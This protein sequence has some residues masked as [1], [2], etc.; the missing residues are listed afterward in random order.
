MQ[1]SATS[2]ILLLD[3]LLLSSAVSRYGL[4]LIKDP[5]CHLFVRHPGRCDV[6]C[7]LRHLYCWA[8]GGAT[9]S[10]T[11]PSMQGRFKYS[12]A[13]YIAL[14]AGR[15]VQVACR[16]LRSDNRGR[17][18][19][20]S[21]PHHSMDNVGYCCT[22]LQCRQTAALAPGFGPAILMIRSAIF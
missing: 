4:T 9:P 5:R 17:G 18:H 19:P 13:Q 21:N 15:C 11:L 2:G 1:C 16:L 20:Y 3:V 22:H 7:T 12:T 10:L 14:L 8:G 6:H